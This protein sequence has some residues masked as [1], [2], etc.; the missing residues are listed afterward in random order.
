MVWESREIHADV[1]LENT[2]EGRTFEDVAV[3]VAWIVTK[4]SVKVV[5]FD[6]SVQFIQKVVL[7][8]LSYI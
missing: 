5:V 1:W 8:C 6:L 3:E 7:K 2:E 4:R